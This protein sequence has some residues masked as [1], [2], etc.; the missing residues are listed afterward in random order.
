PNPSN[1]FLPTQKIARVVNAKIAVK[2]AVTHSAEIQISMPTKLNNL[3]LKNPNEV[4]LP[5]QRLQICL[6]KLTENK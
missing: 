1:C 2:I 3:C 5:H 6:C 4:S